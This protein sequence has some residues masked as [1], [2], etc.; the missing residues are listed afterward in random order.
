MAQYTHRYISPLGDMIMSG[1]GE[2]LTDLHFDGSQNLSA[3]RE[4]IYVADFAKKSH[5]VFELTDKWLD[6]YF[7]GCQP[8]FTPPLIVKSTPFRREVWEILLTIP[9]GKTITYGEIAQK[10]ARQRGLRRM[11]AQAVGN[12]VGRNPIA[13]IIPCHRVIGTNG[14]LVGYAAG[15]EKKAALL[16]LEQM[17]QERNLRLQNS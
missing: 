8:N 16:R 11:S 1:D 12:A 13:L 6:L 7:S 9:Y 14:T 17:G 3:A 15:T 5:T 2:F 4:K 10:I